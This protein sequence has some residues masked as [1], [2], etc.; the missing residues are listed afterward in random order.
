MNSMNLEAALSFEAPTLLIRRFCF[1]HKVSENSANEAFLETKKFLI[2]CANNRTVAYSPSKQVDDMWH[3]FIL[4]S[5]DYFKFC[6]LVGGYIHH[7]PSES[8]CHNNYMKT[9]ED[10]HKV[11]GEVNIKYWGKKLADCESSSCDCCS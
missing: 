9:I 7:Q 4:H 2:L 3:N 11:F 8:R 1:D 6:N 10:I 5:Q